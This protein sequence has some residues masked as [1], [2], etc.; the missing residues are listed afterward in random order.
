MI[1]AD[2]FELPTGPSMYLT[3]DLSAWNSAQV[4]AGM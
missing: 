4:G 1:Q 2:D 3:G